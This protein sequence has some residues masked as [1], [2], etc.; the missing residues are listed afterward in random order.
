MR[1]RLGDV[2]DDARTLHR[3]ALLQL[4]LQGGIATRGHRNLFHHL[5][6]PSIAR[7]AKG[8]HEALVDFDSGSSGPERGPAN[9]LIFGPVKGQYN[10][11]TSGGFQPYRLYCQ[12]FSGHFSPAN[13]QFSEK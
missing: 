3:L 5:F 2:F 6:C 13:A 12:S 11:H 9:L 4:D 1:A 7:A 10:I 8:T